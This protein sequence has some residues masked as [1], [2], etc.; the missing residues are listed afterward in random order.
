MPLLPGTPELLI[1]VLLIVGRHNVFLDDHE[2]SREKGNT[3]IPV[4]DVSQ[5][6]NPAV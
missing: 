6:T 1:L 3:G 2:S 4:E 5:K